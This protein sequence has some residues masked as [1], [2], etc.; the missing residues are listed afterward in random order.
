MSPTKM[1][2]FYHVK[3]HMPSGATLT[4]KGDLGVRSVKEADAQRGFKN[5]GGGEASS[6]YFGSH[7]AVPGS[8]G[9]KG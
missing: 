2:E 9:E 8:M 1:R 4:P 7:A 6:A 5:H 3:S